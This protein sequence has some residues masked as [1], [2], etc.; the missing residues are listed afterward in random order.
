M[1]LTRDIKDRS[2][3]VI[4]LFRSTFADSEGPAEGDLIG[5]LVRDLIDTTPE[6]DLF[7]FAALDDDVVTAAILFTRLT[8]AEDTRTVFLLSPVAVATDQQGKGVGQKLIRHGL[9]T[10]RKEGVDVAFT[11]GD[12]KFYGRVGFEQISEDIARAPQPLQYPHGWL[13][14]PLT[15]TSLS[16]LQGASTCVAA[17]NNPE[18][19]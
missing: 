6:A 11:Y 8:Y 13:G 14:Q 16:P 5:S 7:G 2:E 10:L 3:A 18:L 4:A 12:I 15:T 1:Q 9:D 17:F 19:W